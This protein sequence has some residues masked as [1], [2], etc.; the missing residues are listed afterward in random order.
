MNKI[1][2]VKTEKEQ[3]NYKLKE[4]FELVYA[5]WPVVESEV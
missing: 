4:N 3:L 5:T 2:Q 1:I